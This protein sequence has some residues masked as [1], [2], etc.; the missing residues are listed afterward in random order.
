MVTVGE[1]ENLLIFEIT[2]NRLLQIHFLGKIATAIKFS[3]EGSIIVIGTMSSEIII[4]EWKVNQ[5]LLKKIYQQAD[6]GP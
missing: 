1:D 3:P 2:E 6:Q 4:F 5:I